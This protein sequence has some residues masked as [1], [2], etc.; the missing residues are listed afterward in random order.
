MER[1]SDQSVALAVKTCQI[2]NQY[3]VL[4]VATTWQRVDY[5]SR[6]IADKY[7]FMFKTICRNKFTCENGSVIYLV[8]QASNTR[9]RRADLILYDIDIDYETG[10]I[11]DYIE[12]RPTP[13]KLNCIMEEQTND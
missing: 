11:L 10:R 12:N 5:W 6:H 2:H 7:G 13:F 1:L 4:I 3:C 9:G 8:S